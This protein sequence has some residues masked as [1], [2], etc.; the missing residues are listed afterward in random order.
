[1][2]VMFY[3]YNSFE[4]IQMW[5]KAHAYRLRCSGDVVRVTGT[6]AAG[7]RSI[8]HSKCILGQIIVYVYLCKCVNIP[9][10]LRHML[11]RDV[12]PQLIW[13]WSASALYGTESL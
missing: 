2:C 1:M 5:T 13:P 4:C 12:R 7:S 8:K 11:R 10:W 3:V 6:L 9:F